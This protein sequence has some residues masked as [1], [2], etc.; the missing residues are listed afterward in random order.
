MR[1]LMLTHAFNSLAQRL[2]L[3]LTEAGH[4]LSVGYDINDAVTREAVA[5]W[6]PDL[7]LAPFLKRAIPEDV[8]RAL[9]CLVVHPGPL[10]DRGPSA[11]DHAIQVGRASWGVTVLQARAEMDAGP[12][13]AHRSFAMR[14]DAKS[15]LYRREVTEAAVGAVYEALECLG[16]GRGP[17]LPANEG[18]EGEKPLLRRDARRIDWQRM[19]TVEVLARIRAADGQPGVEDVVHGQ[20]VR[21]HDAH[22]APGRAG[23][24]GALLGRGDEAVLRAT[25]DGAIW[26]GHLSVTLAEGGRRIK[27]PAVAALRRLGARLPPVVADHDAPNRVT[28]AEAGDVA[29]IR[30]PFLNGAM[31]TTRSRTLAAA[32]GDAASGRARDPAERWAR[33]LVQR[34]RPCDHRGLGPPG[35]GVLGFDQRHRRCLPGDARGDRGLGRGGDA[36]QCRCRR[37]LHG[38]GR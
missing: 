32:I 4:D 24:P 12:V 19:R 11:L 17:I 30:F 33:V 37:R 38:A 5:L 31:S 25:A 23:P 20:P 15:S 21:L 28:T 9:P 26:I 22:A 16:A 6:R 14:A 18:P 35:R 3:G 10:G 8:W 7:I 27:L 29:I 1:I 36:W 2:W 34:H 13:C